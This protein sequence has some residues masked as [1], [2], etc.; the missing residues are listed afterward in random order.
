LAS[1]VPCGSADVLSELRRNL[2]KRGLKDTQIDHRL[3]EM[4]SS[5]PDAEV[6][7]YDRL[8]PSMTNDAKDRHVLAAA[9]R[10]GAVVLVT[11]NVRDFP[12]PALAPYDIQAV[13][14]DDF[15]LDQLELWPAA[16]LDALRQQASRYRRDPRTVADLLETLRAD[17]SGCPRFAGACLRAL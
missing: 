4:T 13:H 17:S 9:V 1:I 16:V 12:P 3:N 5:F 14:Q 2:L 15:L 11:E 10:G 6:A 7:G 8:I